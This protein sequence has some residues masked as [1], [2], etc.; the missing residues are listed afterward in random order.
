MNVRALVAAAAFIAMAIGVAAIGARASST[1]DGTDG[2][3]E[4]DSVPMTT[5]DPQPTN[6]G[7]ENGA[8]RPDTA[9]TLT[10][11]SRHTDGGRPL[12]DIDFADPSALVND[13]GTVLYSTNVD[14]VDIQTGTI[15]ADGALA[16]G[17]DALVE[18]PAWS[19][20][21]WVWAPSVRQVGSS[22]FVM[23]YS[24]LDVAS[25]RQ[26]IS[27]AIADAP[28]GPFVDDTTEPLV[29]QRD[30][31]GSIDPDTVTVGATTYLLWKSDGNC[32]GQTTSIWIARLSADGRALVEAAAPL[33]RSDQSWEQGVVEAPSMIQH[34]GSFYLFYSGGRWDRAS[35][36]IAYAVCDSVYG[37]CVKPASQPLLG[38]YGDV[39]GPG[40]ADVFTTRNGSTYVVYHGWV[41]GVGYD[42]GGRRALFSRPLAF[43]GAK[44][45]FGAPS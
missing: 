43:D 1:P 26:C 16:D 39:L 11:A 18:P 35:Y 45:V 3:T 22:S 17:S 6:F 37:P 2:R 12:A 21:G 10:R 19:E 34:E 40:G 13:A 44:P 30:L 38:S 14:D 23:Y 9:D 29:C 24:T 7:G 42:A 31:G 25:G 4:V 36:G 8:A 20:A 15:D 27:V 28:R 41:D 5:R 32:C 33:I